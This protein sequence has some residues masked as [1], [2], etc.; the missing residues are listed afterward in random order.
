MHE[1]LCGKMQLVVLH[2]K[3]DGNRP[4]NQQRSPKLIVDIRSTSSRRVARSCMRP[5][6]RPD[7]VPVA[8]QRFPVKNSKMT[9][10]LLRDD[11]LATDKATSEVFCD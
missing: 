7:T 5:N 4:L 1:N 8:S 3:G 9:D 11:R 2:L 6:W 10:L